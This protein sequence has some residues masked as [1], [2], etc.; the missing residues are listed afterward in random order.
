MVG[1]SRGA[2]A[3]L[4]WR[5]ALFYWHGFSVYDRFGFPFTLLGILWLEDL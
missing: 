4:L 3:V 1:L 5:L 2:G